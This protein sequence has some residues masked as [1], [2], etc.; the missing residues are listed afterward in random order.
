MTTFAIKARLKT[1]LFGSDTIVYDLVEDYTE[2][3]D[4]SYGNGGGDYQKR[5]RVVATFTT[6]AEALVACQKFNKYNG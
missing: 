6:E 4:P 2:W 3:Y 1:R 5:T